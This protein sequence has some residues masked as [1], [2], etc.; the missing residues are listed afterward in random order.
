[1][2]SVSRRAGPPQTGHVV[3]TNSGTWPSGE[4][5]SCV[6]SICSGSSTGRAEAADDTAGTDSIVAVGAVDHRNRRAPVTLAADTPVLEAIG[7]GLFAKA[8][9]LG[10][11]GHLL[12]RFEWR[13]AGELAGVDEDGV[14]FADEGQFGCFGGGFWARLPDGWAAHTSSRTRSRVRR[15]RAR[16]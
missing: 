15:A 16:T 1:M 7:G 5:P 6:I 2:V 11:C 13:E 9:R 10:V 12:L 3:L 4:P 8:V 14:V